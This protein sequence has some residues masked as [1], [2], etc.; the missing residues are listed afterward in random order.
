[1]TQGHPV[2]K[3]MA[4]QRPTPTPRAPLRERILEAA[5]CAFMEN[6]YSGASLLDI[7]T[8]AKVSKREIYAVCEDKGALLRNA[9]ADRAERMRFPLELPTPK[10]RGALAATLAAFGTTLLGG[11]CSPAV[12]AVY[13]L[14]ISESG[15]APEV[16][17]LLD[18]VGRKA[19]RA[20]LA[21]TLAQAQADGLIGAGEPATM[22]IDF[23]ALL[24]GDLLLQLL[25]RVAEPPSLKIMEQKAREA[26]EKFL[27]LYPQPAV[28]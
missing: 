11:V 8:R 23:F 28:S 12:R 21:Q 1:M 19:S 5:F 26:T 18:K 25:L 6:G 27:R 13:W 4:K 9:I 17:K 7:A 2:K 14:A 10:D 24:W 16:G 22:A 20:A 3:G 15:N